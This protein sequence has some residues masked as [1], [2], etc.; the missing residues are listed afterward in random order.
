MKNKM[1]EEKSLKILE[2]TE[3]DLYGRGFNGYD[4]MK[5]INRDT[6]DTVKMKVLRKLSRDDEVI[7]ILE[8]QR[9][10]EFCDALRFEERNALDVMSVLSV[11]SP[12]LYASKEY[13][14]AD[15]AH[16]HQFHNSNLGFFELEREAKRKPT[17]ISFHDPWM[18]TGRCVHPTDCK[19]FTEGCGGCERL[20]THFPFKKDMSA[21]MWQ[22]KSDFFKSADV[23]IIV[24]SEY[25][26]R[27]VKENPYTRDMTV[28]LIPFGVNVSD[29]DLPMTKGE[30]RRLL[31]I[32]K[33]DFVLFFRAQENFKGTDYIVKALKRFGNTGGITL[34]TCSQIGLLDEIKDRYRII[35]LGNI[36]SDTVKKCFAA[37]DVF[38][39]PSECESFGMM[40]L[41]AM[42]AGR[43]VVVF[44]NTAL[45]DVTNAPEVGVLVKNLDSDDL[46]EKIKYLMDNKEERI[47][48]GKAGRELAKEKYSLTGY[49][50]RI[51]EVYRLAYERQSYKL[52][53]KDLKEHPFNTNDPEVKKLLFHLNGIYRRLFGVKA[54]PSELL[55]GADFKPCSPEDIDYQNTNVKKAVAAFNGQCYRRITSGAEFFTPED[56]CDMNNKSVTKNNPAGTAPDKSGKRG[57]KKVSIVIPVYNGEN[58]MR[59]A[60]DSALAQTYRNIEVI[61]VN[62]GSADNTDKIARS[63]GEKIVYLKKE[64]GGVSTALNLALEKMTGDYFSWLSHDDRYYPQK[65]ERE[66]R[67]L[68]ENGFLDKRIIP[69]SDYDLMDENSQVYLVAVK[70]HDE[71]TAKPEYS[72]LHGAINGLTLLIP[73]QAFTECGNFRT[74]L[75]CVQDYVLWG[76]MMF[77]GYKFLHIPEVLVTTRLHRMQQGNTSPVMVS[78]GEELWINLVKQTDKETRERLEGS[79][80]VFMRKMYEFMK[81]MPYPKATEYVENEFAGLREK[82]VSDTNSPKVTVAIPFSNGVESVCRAAQSVLSQTYKNIEI[83]LIDVDSSED[84]A[85]LN[86][87]VSKAPQ[88]SILHLEENSG[89]AD[90]C[91]AAIHKAAGEYI[92]FIDQYDVFVPEKIEFQV[93]EMCVTGADFSHTCYTV[94]GVD[95]AEET[96]DTS[97]IS[98]R[99]IPE[100]INDRRIAFSTVMVK[101]GFLR[102]SKISFADSFRFGGDVCFYLDCL[103]KTEALVIPEALSKLYPD[104]EASRLNVSFKLLSLK[105]VLNHVLS[106]PE[107][108]KY[109]Y[110]ISRLCAECISYNN[111]ENVNIEILE[112]L[113]GNL[114]PRKRSLLRRTLSAIKH[115][116]V[117]STLKAGFAKIKRRIAQ[118]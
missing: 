48:R 3:F 27:L 16:Y 69:Y 5:Q 42:A 47:S 38:L 75:R 114:L 18:M 39:M 95:G 106:D 116:G 102:K 96:A 43:P 72:L 14:E 99:V 98:G 30:V 101:T 24:H 63:Y 32:P 91:N 25:M 33:D 36:K 80:Y 90:A 66:M 59:E 94:I 89:F 87:F 97:N 41:E 67:F 117:I 53:R 62:D 21:A 1:I 61:V 29:F 112:S 28:H 54:K 58:Y 73:R 57:K 81:T 4:I 86:D 56:V 103:K 11:S 40:A 84:I 109:D 8:K 9:E 76:D 10:I 15:V 52:G 65:I 111:D 37:C 35:E 46:Y 83:L 49:E 93:I 74:D 105:T 44:D 70:E 19:K 78:E 31:G 100:I 12:A 92:A 13:K 79:E 20:F 55:K 7:P 17:V 34:L 104:R 88:A 22:I 64:N 82:F 71:L 110:Q 85:P 50:K 23:D 77:A 2:V 51:N 60:I 107:L 68:E 113:F 6:R 115:R 108:S 26:Y 45:P 118:K